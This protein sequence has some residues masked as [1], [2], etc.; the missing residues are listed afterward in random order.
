MKSIEVKSFDSPDEVRTFDGGKLELIEL[1]GRTVGRAT[2]EPGWQW[3][4]SLG[5]LPRQKAA[6]RLTFSTTF[7]AY[8]T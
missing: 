8:S 7:R 4:K 2:F 3:S 5:R 1:N 6:R